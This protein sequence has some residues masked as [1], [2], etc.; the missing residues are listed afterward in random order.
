MN[1]SVGAG[2]SGASRSFRN[3]DT[4]DK[5]VLVTTYTNKL[6]ARRGRLRPLSECQTLWIQRQYSGDGV[7]TTSQV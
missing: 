5:R 6:E 1:T 4:V 7:R 3:Q 2:Q